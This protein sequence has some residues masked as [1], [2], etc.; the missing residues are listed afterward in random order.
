MADGILNIDKPTGW[1]SHDVVGFIRRR[2]GT[3]RVGHAGTLDPFATGVLLVCVGQATRVAEYLMASDK[4]YRAVAELGVITDTYD[5]D[6]TVQARAPV[7][8]L[9]EEALRRALAA[10]EG[11][12]EQVPPAY[13][14]IK[15]NGVPAHQ[16]ARRGEQVELPSRRVRIHEARLISWLAPHL[17]FEVTCEAGTYI[18]SIA[19][20]LGTRLGCG[21]TLV[22]LTR[23]RS[24]PF[25]LEQSVATSDLGDAA[26]VEARLRPIRHA[27]YDL[28][29]APV[30]DSDIARLLQGQ[31]ITAAQ[32]PATS[33]GYALGPD[34]Q[35]HAI[36]RYDEE[37]RLWRPVK[38]FTSQSD[39]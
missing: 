33:I 32:P 10:F 28:T 2:L 18:R 4:T 12:I 14:A 35:V 19:H 20:D 22:A 1:T 31:A 9:S 38:V 26:A 7:P 27:L 25:R 3:R 6:G 39:G 16:R 34:E 24:G 17:E 15:Q 37:H 30:S 13:S 29:P 21:A 5:V 11:D 8:D 36:L 23:T